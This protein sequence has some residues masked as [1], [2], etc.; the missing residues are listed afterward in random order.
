MNQFGCQDGAAI[1]RLREERD[2]SALA[3]AERVGIK[4]RSLYNIEL[5]NKPAGLA[6][7]VRIAR[8]LRV[9]VD[10]ILKA[11]E[12]AETEDVAAALWPAPRPA[13]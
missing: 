1:R 6:V 5:G 10:K 4:R 12:E 11:D 7:L 9:P 2:L 13:T 8:E 3:L